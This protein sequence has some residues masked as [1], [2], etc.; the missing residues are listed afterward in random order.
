MALSIAMDASDIQES[1]L[2]HDTEHRYVAV[3]E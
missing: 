2:Y 1:C 3:S